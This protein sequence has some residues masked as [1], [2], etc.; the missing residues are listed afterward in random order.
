M[1]AKKIVELHQMAIN[2]SREEMFQMSE[3]RKNVMKNRDA[4]L[5]ESENKTGKDFD[6]YE[7]GSSISDD[8]P[9]VKVK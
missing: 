2:Y 1:D 8:L 9:K 5:L 6:D 7:I 3:E 4:Y